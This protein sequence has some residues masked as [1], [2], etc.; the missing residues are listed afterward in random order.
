MNL[1]HFARQLTA[2][3]EEVTTTKVHGCR[4]SIKMKRQDSHLLVC[5][6]LSLRFYSSIVGSRTERLSWD[7]A[8]I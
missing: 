3:R 8:D 5:T 1:R 4:E 6:G 7:H 2:G